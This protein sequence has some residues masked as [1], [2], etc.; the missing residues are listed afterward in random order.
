MIDGYSLT[1]KHELK[2]SF[3]TNALKR[4][5]GSFSIPNKL[6]VLPCLVLCEYHGALKFKDE[7]KCFYCLMELL[8]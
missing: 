7:P 1:Y 5:E 6:H 3:T 4:N 2:C 8:K